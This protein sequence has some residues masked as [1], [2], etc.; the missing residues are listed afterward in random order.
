MTAMIRELSINTIGNVV[1][2]GTDMTRDERNRELVRLDLIFYRQQGMTRRNAVKR[3]KLSR[4]GVMTDAE[5]ESLSKQ[6]WA[7]VSISA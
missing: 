4:P 3:V 7:T 6:I 2:A 1:G 5:L